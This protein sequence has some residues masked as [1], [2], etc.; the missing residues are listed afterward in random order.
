MSEQPSTPPTAVSPSTLPHS[1]GPESS[2][3]SGAINVLV[4]DDDSETAR[5]LKR[6]LTAMGNVVEIKSNGVEALQ[7]L[8]HHPFDVVLSDVAM[9]EMDGYELLH[10]L[11]A[12]NS[13]VPVVLLTGDPSVSGAARA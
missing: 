12:V 4:V 6:S 1:P 3:R 10:A 11:R 9:P 8:Q 13:E 2:A 7:A 5:A